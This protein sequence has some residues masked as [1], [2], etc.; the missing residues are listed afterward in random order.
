V[1]RSRFSASDF[2]R[3][4]REERCTL[5]QYIGELC[6]Y[7]LNSPHQ[8]N[9]TAHSLRIACGNGLRPE[10]W[11]PFQTR[12]KIPRILEYY[13]S[14]GGN[15][16]LYNCEVRPGE[17]GKFPSSL[18]HRLPV[19]LLK[20]DAERGEPWRNEE[21]YSMRCEPNKVGEAVGL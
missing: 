19:A 7:L 11:E 4:V 3:D 10:V 2:W 12:F 5:F 13:V 15:F 1:I 18:A 9:E 21:G 14:T 8:E 16:S 20:F 17:F 6:R